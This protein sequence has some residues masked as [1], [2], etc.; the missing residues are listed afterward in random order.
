VGI[1]H[2]LRKIV[3][4]TVAFFA[5]ASVLTLPAKSDKA[6]APLLA[7]A[8]IDPHVLALFERSCQDCHSENTRYPWYSYVAPVSWLIKYDVSGGRKHMNLSQWQDYPLQRRERLL[9][10]IAN[11]VKDR[12]MP[13]PQYLLIHRNARP[14]D[15]E[16]D[17]IFQWT[18]KER[19]RLIN[20]A[21]Q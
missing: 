9:S 16:I 4:W 17:A 20:A 13:V 3:L 5:V 2:R 1:G 18:Q 8:Q 7:G 21:P 6:G 19:A 10:E 12:D 14:S 11:Q 15:T